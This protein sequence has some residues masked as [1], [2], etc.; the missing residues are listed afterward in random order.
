MI[1]LGLVDD[2]QLFRKSLRMLLASL[3]SYQVVLEA[4]NGLDLQQKI[5]IAKT[6]PDIL[7]VDIAMPVMD[8]YQTARWMTE[9]YPAVRLVALSMNNQEYS[10]REMLA[11]GCCA[12]LFKDTHPDELERALSDVHQK[13]FYNGNLHHI[14]MAKWT[15][16][17]NDHEIHLT[18]K[19]QEFVQHASSDMTYK[20]IAGLMSL[21]ERT[22]DGYRAAVFAKLG[23]QSRTGMVLEAFRRGWV[24]L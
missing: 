19:E 8:G 5:Q 1:Q 3:R 21:S 2:H 13:G 7:L 4:N 15:R 18:E 14:N 20:Q 16:S 9:H 11:S 12:F 10:I 23:V 22:I 24:K 6:L 17:S